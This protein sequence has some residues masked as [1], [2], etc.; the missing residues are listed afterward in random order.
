VRDQHP[1]AREAEERAKRMM[2]RHSS[3]GAMYP[4]E[5]VIVHV[6]YEKKSSV[7]PPMLMHIVHQ[8]PYVCDE[9]DDRS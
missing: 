7:Q 1:E 8:L 6:G 2:L 5:I 4:A 3:D 9:F